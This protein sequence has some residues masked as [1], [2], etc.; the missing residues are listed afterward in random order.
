MIRRR[1]QSLVLLPTLA[2][3]FAA[4]AEAQ[5]HTA[6]QN[7]DVIDL[8]D[9]T[10]QMNVS[11]VWSLSDAWRIEV[12]GHSL[13]RQPTGTLEEFE[14]RPGLAGMPFLAPFANRLDDTA[15]TSS[16]ATS[17]GRFR[18]PATLMARGRGS[19]WSSRPTTTAR[20]SPASWISTGIRNS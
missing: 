11:V 7:G 4:P 12:K 6:K 8:A 17:A 16:S 20:G 19:L 13:V 9:T 2:C 10:A 5:R 3:L 14:A 18:V 15:S 1:L